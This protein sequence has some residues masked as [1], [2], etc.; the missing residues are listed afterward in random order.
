VVV[1]IAL[2]TLALVPPGHAS[3]MAVVLHPEDAECFFEPGD[4]PGVDVFF[5]GECT[6]ITTPTGTLQ[7]VARGQLPAGYTLSETFEG[8]VPCFGGT[9]H[10]VATKSGQVRATCHVQ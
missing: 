2:L 3:A 1:V 10:I 8:D 4:V 6:L 5:P 7:V 9:G